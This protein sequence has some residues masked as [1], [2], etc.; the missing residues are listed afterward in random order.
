[1]LDPK[2]AEAIGDSVVQAA[3]SR[4]AD[5]IRPLLSRS[6]YYGILPSHLSPSQ[7]AN[8]VSAAKGAM[9]RDWRYWALTAGW[10]ALVV[11]AA[12]EFLPSHGPV[13]WLL[14]PAALPILGLQIYITKVALRRLVRDKDNARQSEV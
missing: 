7:E 14:V 13:F 5:R 6:M 1:M 11:G 10:L 2:Q 8:L 3:R 4:S 9:A 12:V